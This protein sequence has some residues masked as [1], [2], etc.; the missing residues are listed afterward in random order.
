[1]VTNTCVNTFEGDQLDS[2]NEK[3]TCFYGCG[4]A[5]VTGTSLG[6]LQAFDLL[7]QNQIGETVVD[8]NHKVMYS[9]IKGFQN[10]LLCVDRKGLLFHWLWKYDEKTRQ[11]TFQLK[12][13][14]YPPFPDENEEI[15]VKY[16]SRFPERLVDFNEHIG[17]TNFQDMFCIFDIKKGEIGTWVRTGKTVLCQQVFE[18]S[19][20]WAGSQGTLYHFKREKIRQICGNNRL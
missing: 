19:A 1:M 4:P 16:K 2:K 20:Y 8:Y 7:N 15:C 9:D 17:I 12:K 14:F 6:R 18:T 10:S 13:T 11:M 3:A 5:L